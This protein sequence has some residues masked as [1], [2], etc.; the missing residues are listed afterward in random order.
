MSAITGQVPRA[1]PNAGVAADVLRAIERRL[2]TIIESAPVCLARVD[3]DGTIRAMNMAARTMM[4]AT[5][6]SDVLRKSIFSF[7]G[8]D[9]QEAARQFVD[10]TCRG[11]SGTLR[12]SMTGVSAEGRIVDVN[13]VALPPRGKAGAPSALLAFRDMT[14]WTR[15]EGLLLQKEREA[16][17][18]TSASDAARQAG[19]KARAELEQRVAEL[20]DSRNELQRRLDDREAAYRRT[21]EQRDALRKAV[22]DLRSGED[23]RV[24]REDAL[25]SEMA[26]AVSARGELEQQLQ[27]ADLAR[28]RLVREAKAAIAQRVQVA[29]VAQDR[30][31]GERLRLEA[32]LNELRARP[33][34][35]AAADV[36]DDERQTLRRKLDQAERARAEAVA[37]CE[38]MQAVLAQ[39]HARR[40]TGN[41]VAKQWLA[42]RA[43]FL[44]VLELARAEFDQL[45]EWARARAGQAPTAPVVGAQTDSARRTTK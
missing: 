6:P 23:A 10:A 24:Q 9:Y 20:E 22:E 34:A 35:A 3:G 27:E 21:L 39:A 5:K 40:E 30:V 12:L 28:R 44:R 29:K 45:D 31:E 43:E 8:A 17:E 13:A 14:G 11:K 26:A 37:E 19:T 2:R 41:Q 42:R 18:A 25:R 15:L 36:D 38:S 7:V 32:E 16:G 33:A 4:G 1:A